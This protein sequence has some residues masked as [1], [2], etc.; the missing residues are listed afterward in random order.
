MKQSSLQKIT[1]GI[2]ALLAVVLAFKSF[3]E[4]DLWWMFRVGEWMWENQSIPTEDVFSFTFPG[5][6]WISVKW[7]FELIAFWIT[8]ILGAP[9]MGLLQALANILLLVIVARSAQYT[10]QLVTQRS[11]SWNHEGILISLVLFLFATEFRMILRPEMTSHVLTALVLL[12]F[13]IQRYSGKSNIL[14]WLIPLN[15]FWVNMH[16]AYGTG[17]VLIGAFMGAHILE[18][19]FLKWTP[20]NKKMLLLGGLALLAVSINPR[21]PYMLIHP[22]VI[23]TQVGSNHYTSELNSLFY[24]ADYYFSF[25]DPYIFILLLALTVLGI[26]YTTVKSNVKFI[27]SI[28][29]GL[30]LVA[31]MLTYLGLTGHRNIPFA[32]IGLMPIF[33]VFAILILARLN[34]PVLFTA[35]TG[36]VAMVFYAGVV[37][38]QYYK[39]FTPT[40]RYGLKVSAIKNPVGAA[41]FVKANNISGR[42]FSDYLTSAYFLWEL[43]PNFESYIDLRDLDVFPMTHFQRF[44]EVAFRPA[45]FAAEHEKYQFDY[46]MLYRPNFGPLHNYLFNASDWV[47]VYAD[48]VACVYVSQE[49][50]KSNSL[51]SLRDRPKFSPV[52]REEPHPF[53]ATLTTVFNPF[54]ER[55]HDQRHHTKLV[56]STYFEQVGKYQT[57][58]ELTQAV[59]NDPEFGV[60]AR[61]RYG[62]L[63][64]GIHQQNQDIAYLNEAE[65]AFAEVIATNP[66][67]AEAQLGR[68]QVYFR[69]QQYGQ[70]LRAFEMAIAIEPSSLAYTLLAN[71]YN[72]FASTDVQG[73]NGHIANW[74]KYMNKAHKLAPS[75]M[76]VRHAIMLAHCKRNECSMLAPFADGFEARPGMNR[77]ELNYIARCLEKCGIERG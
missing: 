36:L 27:Q 10:Y 34:R 62:N 70:A 53:L 24:A 69:K 20:L 11:I 16:E 45:A 72:M 41:Q 28:G 14:F 47:P 75:D 43:R 38:N 61:L 60:D 44:T 46:V 26:V 5:R 58:L 73:A 15:V 19:V 67:N 7:L 56:G 39:V 57:A 63:L 54:Y 6:D 33:A 8:S 48:A 3:R 32:I 76:Y 74:F 25:K 12:I 66:E 18:A 17:M 50:A 22:Y 64:L 21:G 4:P 55:T 52:V 2:I 77:E 42:C 13:V 68:G 71:C 51:S 59:L 31:L 29:I 23:F 1:F 65:R 40:E 37:S 35:I 49:I 9:G 30:P